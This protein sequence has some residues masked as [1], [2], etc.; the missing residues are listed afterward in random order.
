MKLY[1]GSHF[2]F[3]KQEAETYTELLQFR[4]LIQSEYR[5]QEKTLFDKKEKLFRIKDITK[6]GCEESLMPELKKRVIQLYND[7]Q[8]AFSYMLHSE[9]LQLQT[10]REKL[11]FVTN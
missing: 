2:K 5:V 3:N 7:R 9:T 10:L 8:I 11:N 4:E 1:C 6:W